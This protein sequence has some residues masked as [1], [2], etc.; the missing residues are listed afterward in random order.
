MPP[1]GT[2][3]AGCT[4]TLHRAGPSA[5]LRRRACRQHRSR[6][7]RV[8]G[9]MTSA[10]CR[11]ISRSSSCAIVSSPSATC[12]LCSGRVLTP[13]QI[14]DVCLATYELEAL[15]VGEKCNNGLNLFL[16]DANAPPSAA[17]A[18]DRAGRRR[19]QAVVRLVIAAAIALALSWPAWRRGK[20]AQGLPVAADNPSRSEVT[21][22]LRD[23]ET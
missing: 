5:A 10:L 12:Q 21:I 19:L 23:V 22:A 7:C 4:A 8:L 9:A 20:P 18:H 6:M 17:A 3:V 14:A 1:R 15:Q 2:Q 16:H 13:R 11:S